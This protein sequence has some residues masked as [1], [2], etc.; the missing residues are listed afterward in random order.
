MYIVW[1]ITGFWTLVSLLCTLFG[2]LLALRHCSLCCVHCCDITGFWTLVSLLCTLF[3]VSVT[4]LSVRSFWLHVT[5]SA[6]VD[7]VPSECIWLCTTGFNYVW[8]DLVLCSIDEWFGW[9]VSV[10]F[11]C[12][13]FSFHRQTGCCHTQGC[14]TVVEV[15]HV[16]FIQDFH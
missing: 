6:G 3:Y 12:P 14:Q 7:A 13:V 11:T 15:T 5:Y 10:V 1:D 8:L 16:S 2:N 4:M 9:S